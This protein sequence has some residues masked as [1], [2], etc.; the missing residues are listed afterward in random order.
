MDCLAQV[1]GHSFGCFLL[2]CV[3][4]WLLSN[5]IVLFRNLAEV[6]WLAPNHVSCP[7]LFAFSF[8]D[9]QFSHVLVLYMSQLG[10]HWEESSHYRDSKGSHP[11][12]TTIISLCSLQLTVINSLLRIFWDDFLCIFMVLPCDFDI[13]RQCLCPF[14]LNLGRLVTE[15]IFRSNTVLWS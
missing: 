3:V 12:P 5:W 13:E 10:L 6:V 2:V 11:S 9:S 8:P 14:P 15:E 4:S 7:L 1:S